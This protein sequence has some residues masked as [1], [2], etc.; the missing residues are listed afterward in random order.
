MITPARC[1]YSELLFHYLHATIDDHSAAAF[2]AH[3]SD[4]PQCLALLRQNQTEPEP[5]AWLRLLQNPF[6]AFGPQNSGLPFRDSASPESVPSVSPPTADGAEQMLSGTVQSPPANGLRYACTRHIGSGGSGDVWEAW[7]QLLCRPVALKFLKNSAAPLDETHRFMQEATALARLSHSHIVSIHELQYV[8]GTPVL[9]MEL[10][11][12]P[13]LAQYLKG[14]PCPPTDAATLL[15]QLCQAVEHAHGLGVIHRDLKPS[16]V[17]LKPAPGFSTATPDTRLELAHW[18]PKIADFGLAHIT[19]QPTLTLPGQQLGTPSYMAPEQVAATPEK[20]GPA[21][22]IY[23][24]GTILYE[25]L[26]GRPPFASSDPSLTMAMILRNDPVPPGTLV[27]GIPRDLET[28]CMKCLRKEP[29]SRYSNVA[30]LRQDCIAFLQHR[31]ITA[32]PLSVPSRILAWA[33]RHPAESTAISACLGL[34]VAVTAFAL[35]NAHLSD[36]LAA[37]ALEKVRLTEEKQAIQ[38]K[39]QQEVHAKFDQ[40]LQAH[41]HFLQFIENRNLPQRSNPEALRSEIIRSASELAGPYIELLD[42]KVQAGQQPKPEEIRLAIDYLD[43]AFHNHVPTDYA[44]RIPMLKGLVENITTN[45]L[46]PRQMLETKLRLEGLHARFASLQKEHAKAGQSYE[47][48]ASFLEEQLLT[49]APDDL[50]RLGRLHVKVLMLMNARLAYLE[51]NRPDLALQA[52]NLAE[53]DASRL[54]DAEPA[55]QQWMAL[56]LDVRLNQSQILPPVEAATLATTTLSQFQNT[57]WNSPDVAEKASQIL[58]KLQ[59]LLRPA[60]P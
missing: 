60:T 59:A 7:D 48:M 42:Q 19:D 28:I 14:R 47:N 13:S 6:P 37:E 53:A 18:L 39:Q 26:T 32:R 23:G 57:S 52:N 2:E 24:L 9:V 56:L 31:P 29:Q 12:G 16:N 27:Q 11:T 40:L 38:I 5:E 10:V 22:D 25:L 49:F 1:Q 20:S 41:H 50:A 46:P 45:A 17:L 8:R 15:E 30:A 33:L 55:N 51:A 21:T 3:V 34:L 58:A 54:L 43:M 4:C 36:K 35:R 44:N